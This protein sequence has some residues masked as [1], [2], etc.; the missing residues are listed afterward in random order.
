[1][2]KKWE[3]AELISLNK[4]EYKVLQ[5]A[6]LLCDSGALMSKVANQCKKL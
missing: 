2:R 5:Q 1:M 6:D 4:E 3:A